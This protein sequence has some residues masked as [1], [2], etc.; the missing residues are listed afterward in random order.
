M[1]NKYNL[2]V[3]GVI[4]TTVCFRTINTQRTARD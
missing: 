4:N 2:P 3:I 1:G